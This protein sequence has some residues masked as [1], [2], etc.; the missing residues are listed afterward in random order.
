MMSEEPSSPERRVS[1]EWPQFRL[2]SGGRVEHEIEWWGRGPTVTWL[3]ETA[4]VEYSWP[5]FAAF[6]EGS[7][8]RS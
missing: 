6:T 2:A 5:P 1:V 4:D 7:E 3:I 8:S